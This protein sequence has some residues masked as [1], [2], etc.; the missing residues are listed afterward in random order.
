RTALMSEAATAPKSAIQKILDVV[1]KVGNKVPHPAVIFL[2]LI[3]IV[4]VLSAVFGA[5]G[6][7]VSF[8]VLVPVQAPVEKAAETDLTL[9]DTGAAVKYTPDEHYKIE[10][11]TVTTR[12]LLTTEGIR[13]IYSSLIPSF[14]G[15]TALGLMIVALVGAG[16]A[17]ESGLVK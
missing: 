4:V 17:E 9:Y 3:G 12:S 2:I 10:T 7:S 15:F 5:M 13:F 11:R 14:M 6:T 8:E 1:E 16:V